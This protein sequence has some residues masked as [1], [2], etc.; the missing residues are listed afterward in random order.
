ML[1]FHDYKIDTSIRNLEYRKIEM[2]IYRDRIWRKRKQIRKLYREKEAL[3]KL[4]N[5]AK[6]KKCKMMH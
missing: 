4:R 6:E 1:T 3:K 2:A 5:D